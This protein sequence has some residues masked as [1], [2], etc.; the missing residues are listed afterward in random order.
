MAQFHFLILIQV[1]FYGLKMLC[2]HFA[3]WVSYTIFEFH[4]RKVA[5]RLPYTVKVDIPETERDPPKVHMENNE[6]FFLNTIPRRPMTFAIDKEWIS[7]MIH[8]K[9]VE[10]QKKHGINYRY[11]NFSFVY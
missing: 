2:T 10:F 9:R 5:R 3:C 7:E 6:T 11:K 8:A 1:R 4:C